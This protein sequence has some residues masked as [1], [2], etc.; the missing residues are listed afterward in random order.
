M[1]LR[2]ALF[3]K[4]RKVRQN[5]GLS[6]EFHLALTRFLTGPGF[7]SSDDGLS[8]FLALALCSAGYRLIAAQHLGEIFMKIRFILK[9]VSRGLI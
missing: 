6:L 7:G 4:R 8:A 9:I 3:A 2:R 1:C 5:T